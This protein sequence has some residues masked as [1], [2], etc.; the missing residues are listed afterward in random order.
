MDC[1][2]VEHVH[3]TYRA[4]R[5]NEVVGIDVYAVMPS[6]MFFFWSEAYD[7]LQ[8]GALLCFTFPAV[9]FHSRVL[10]PVL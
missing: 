9:V 1:G 2:A 10:E 8:I 5:E 4:W 6:F 3:Y 7:L